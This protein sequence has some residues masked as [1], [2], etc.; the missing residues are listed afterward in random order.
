MSD[1]TA[2]PNTDPGVFGLRGKTV[3]VT[4]ASSGIGHQIALSCA[5]AGASVVA[6]GRDETRLAAL[7]EQMN[8]PTHRYL[9]AD[10]RDDVSVKHLATQVERLDGVVHSAGI[11]ALA[12]LRMAT[13]KHIE[14]QMHTN[15]LA[16]MLLTQQLLLRSAICNGGSIV[17]VSSISA[18]IGVAGV[19]AYG[20]SKAALEAMARSLALEVAKKAM[21]VNCLAPGLV[22]T[23]MLAAAKANATSLDQTLARYPLGLGRPE[24]VAHAAVFLLSGASRW[25]TGTTITIDGGH[26]VG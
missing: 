18:H 7:V 9:A 4:G 19:S 17:F 23:P 26:T 15:Y 1:V 2:L 22:E 13:R 20:A 25:I 14:S 21:R 11:A 5:L 10:L 12:P 8:G 24:D 16:P 6:T 3:L